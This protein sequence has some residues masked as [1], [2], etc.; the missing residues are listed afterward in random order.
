MQGDVHLVLGVV[1]YTN[2]IG[3]KKNGTALHYLEH[4]INIGERIRAFTM[5]SL[6][7]L[8]INAELNMTMAGPGTGIASFRGF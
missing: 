3:N 1:R 4:N 6:F 2:T 7:A 5:S 8:T